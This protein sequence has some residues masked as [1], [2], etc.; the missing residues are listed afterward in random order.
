MQSTATMVA[1]I[2]KV[3]AQNRLAN[4]ARATRPAA[5]RAVVKLGEIYRPAYVGK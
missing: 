3:R 5:D 2:D 1:T 4:G